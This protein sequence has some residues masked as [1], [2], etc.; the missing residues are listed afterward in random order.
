MAYGIKF[1]RKEVKENY[2][3][4]QDI[5]FLENRKN[6]IPF[7]VE[8]KEQLKEMLIYNGFKITRDLGGAILFELPDN[9]HLSVLLT[10]RYAFFAATGENSLME[11]MAFLN[12]MKDEKLANFDTLKREWLDNFN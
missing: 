11:Q 4:S 8:K 1:Y 9:E 6:I 3:K 5:D 10:N 2:F 7:S 12:F